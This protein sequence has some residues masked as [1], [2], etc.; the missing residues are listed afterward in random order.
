VFPLRGEP[1]IPRTFTGAPPSAA[2]S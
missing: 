2:V 1:Q